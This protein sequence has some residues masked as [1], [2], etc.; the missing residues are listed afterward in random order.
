MAKLFP[1]FFLSLAVA[2]V[3]LGP[4]H[5]GSKDIVVCDFSENRDGDLP[6]TVSKEAQGEI[7]LKSPTAAVLTGE[8]GK[9]FAQAKGA[10]GY[11][12]P[13]V[14]F[15]PGVHP[16]NPEGASGIKLIW[17]LRQAMLGAGGVYELEFTVIPVTLPIDGGGRIKFSL[18]TSEGKGIQDVQV[19]LSELPAISFAGE[20]YGTARVKTN[21][22]SGQVIPVKI[23]LDL[24]K[25]QWAAWIDGQP[26]VENQTLPQALTD[27]HPQMTLG[28]FDFGSEGGLGDKV[29]GSYAI[30]GVKLI[31]LD[32]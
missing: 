23:R 7:P 14:V 15:E 16:N 27:V 6:K 30:G 3:A 26:I 4:L 12:K 24:E 2:T 11:G 18:L 19:H 21:V 25:N 22:G 9:L 32:E 1:G 29:G 17:D 20:K 28:G 31:R 10:D 8:G 5:A 13:L